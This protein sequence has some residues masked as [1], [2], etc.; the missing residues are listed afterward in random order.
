MCGWFHDEISFA[1]RSNRARA[2]TLPAGDR[3]NKWLFEIR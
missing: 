3:R 1:S 2:W